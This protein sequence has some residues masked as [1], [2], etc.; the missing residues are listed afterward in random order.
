MYSWE[1]KADKFHDTDARDVAS[2]MLKQIAHFAIF[3]KWN[4]NSTETRI[5]IHML[6]ACYLLSRA[7]GLAVS[8]LLQLRVY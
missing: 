3:H 8:H 1:A 6:Y 7:I 5:H 2:A 4:P